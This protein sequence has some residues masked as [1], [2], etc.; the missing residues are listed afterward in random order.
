M[1]GCGA[2]LHRPRLVRNYI[3]YYLSGRAQ[4]KITKRR[5]SKGKNDNMWHLIEDFFDQSWVMKALIGAG[6][7]A[8]IIMLASFGQ[9]AFKVISG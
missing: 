6:W 4:A 8:V 3:W 7:L 9:N 2:K 1:A 5:I